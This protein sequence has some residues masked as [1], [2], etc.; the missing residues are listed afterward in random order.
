MDKY[1]ELP[2]LCLGVCFLV[3][4]VVSLVKH[5]PFAFGKL[6][7]YTEESVRDSSTMVGIGTLV[8]GATWIVSRIGCFV[9]ALSAMNDAR[10]YILL[11]GD[12]VTILFVVLGARR[13]V[14]KEKK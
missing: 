11:G 7:K 14:E 10:V 5:K 9:P 13:L 2:F 12:A 3:C 1:L 4:G 8:L 6:D